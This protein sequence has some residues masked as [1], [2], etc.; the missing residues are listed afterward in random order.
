MANFGQKNTNGS[1]FFIVTGPDGLTLAP[2]YTIFGKVSQGMSVVQK[3][4]QTPVTTNPGNGEPSQP[5]EKVMI[6]RVSIIET[7]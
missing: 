5:L 2:S 6:I 7:R 1:Q 3:I 4:A